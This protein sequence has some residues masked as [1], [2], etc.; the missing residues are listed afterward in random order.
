M[1]E[2]P[3]V[4]K[5]RR[6]IA[7]HATGQTVRRVEVHD[8]ELLE[9]TTP[10]GLGRSA[11]GREIGEPR[12]LGKWLAVGLDRGGPTLVFHFR[13][14]GDLLWRPVAEEAGSADAVA[15]HLDEGILS[16][17]SRRLLGGVTYLPAGRDLE[18]A[19]GPLG[20]DA[21]DVDRHQL[22]ELLAG[23]R[24]GLKSALMDQR[25]IAGLGNELVDEILW[26]SGLHPAR[27]AAELA[28]DELADLYSEFRE[29]L[30]RSI[31]AGHVPSGP[32][33]LN[34]QRREDEPR[35]P[36]CGAALQR[37]RVGGRTTFWCP[38][39]QPAPS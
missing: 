32:T 15:F 39:E 18:A 29:V 22:G 13:M 37:G 20:P 17:R 3:D 19:V 35:C 27:P 16:Y 9:G 24:G 10:Q 2:L 33:W 1:P 11:V 28:E 8:P 14:T 21:A 23:R 34:A 38:R 25:M 26:R 6:T 7:E 12:R 30:R 5:H 4:E 36:R 31:R